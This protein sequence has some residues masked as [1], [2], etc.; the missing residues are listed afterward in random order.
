MMNTDKRDQEKKTKKGKV[1]KSSSTGFAYYAAEL[2]V[3][4]YV[5]V[6]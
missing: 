5:E 6:M 3:E 4:F 1:Q 2:C